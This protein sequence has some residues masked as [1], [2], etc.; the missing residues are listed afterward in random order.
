M[1]LHASLLWRI[2]GLYWVYDGVGMAYVY[3]RSI[4]LYMWFIGNI[5]C[6][7]VWLVPNTYT[8]TYLVPSNPTLMCMVKFLKFPYF[9]SRYELFPHFET[10]KKDGMELMHSKV[11]A[12]SADGCLSL[13]AGAYVSLWHR[14]MSKF[15]RQATASAVCWTM[16]TAEG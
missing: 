8:T 6:F 13:W 12:D 11:Y 7:G 14:R 2:R 9:S 15:V 5:E 10:Y 4:S 3:V 1:S 16:A